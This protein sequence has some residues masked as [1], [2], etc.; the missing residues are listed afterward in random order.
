MLDSAS[1]ISGYYKTIR[2]TTVFYSIKYDVETALI[3][4][5]KA[6]HMMAEIGQRCISNWCDS[7][8]TTLNV[9]EK[10]HQPKTCKNRNWSVEVASED[11]DGEWI[12]LQNMH[13][14][15]IFVKKYNKGAD[16]HRIS[17]RYDGFAEDIELENAESE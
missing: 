6:M 12:N 10:E 7:N 13:Q 1:E 8:N 11:K 4:G 15:R 3:K 16:R 14:L 17:N 2:D 5:H 9:V